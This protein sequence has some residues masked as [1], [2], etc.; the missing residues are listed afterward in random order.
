MATRLGPVE[1]RQGF[2]ADA[3]TGPSDELVPALLASASPEELAGLVLCHAEAR[4]GC[5]GVR[6]AWT[7]GAPSLQAGSN[8]E[9][10]WHAWPVLA[11]EPEATREAALI[12]TV[13]TGGGEAQTALASRKTTGATVLTL[14]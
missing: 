6:V 13:C 2:G 8:G 9:P 1:L 11:P 5:R 14:D 12:E 7:L 10:P 4:F 3:G